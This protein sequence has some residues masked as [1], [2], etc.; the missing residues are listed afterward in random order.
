[1]RGQTPGMR[2]GHRGRGPWMASAAGLALLLLFP[3]SAGPLAEL[4]LR[5]EGMT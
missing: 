4:T 2:A 1:M 3:L 5:V